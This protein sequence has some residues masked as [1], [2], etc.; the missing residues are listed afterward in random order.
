M[1][2]RYGCAE[3]DL[4]HYDCFRTP[5]R[6][7][8]DGRLDKPAWRRAPR[9]GR[10]VDLVS[11]VPGFL[12]TRMASLWDD[13][14]L[15]VAF[16]ASEPDVRARLAERDSL[17]WTENDV[18]V[19]IGGED[20]YYEFQVNALGTVYEVF[21]VW[22][23]ALKKGSRFDVP[24]FDPRERRADVIGGFQDGLRYGRHP[25]GR[26]W[27]FMDWDFPGLRAAVQVRGTLN[28]ASDVDEGW[29]AEI[30]FP[31]SGMKH[32][33]GGR[34]LPPRDG[35][36]WRLDFSRFELLRSCGVTVEPHPGWALNKHGVYDSHIPECFSFIRFRTAFL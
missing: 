6:I 28:D 31:W 25:R 32:L 3:G 24:E 27:A 18:E 22:Q 10:F 9:S 20:C 13:E 33:A 11:G 8:V 16:W 5:R 29:T 35:D 1:T 14:A 36:V 15:Y 7:R 34:P 12:E 21:Y 30:A 19:F 23:D 4:A 17:V 26:R 2:K